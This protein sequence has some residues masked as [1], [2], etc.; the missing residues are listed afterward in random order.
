MV[1]L[2]LPGERLAGLISKGRVICL[3]T[4]SRAQL[5]G[6]L[7]NLLSQVASMLECPF[8]LPRTTQ[9]K[10]KGG[11]KMNDLKK[12]KKK[13]DVITG[14]RNRKQTWRTPQRPGAEFGSPPPLLSCA[15][16]RVAAGSRGLFIA[17]LLYQT[18]GSSLFSCC[19]CLVGCRYKLD[20]RRCGE[21]PGQIP[22]RRLLT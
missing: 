14:N 3:Q 16:R 5:P 15:G 20:C 6:A 9:P 11:G 17:R 4:C 19:C 10:K 2:C 13:K 18:H 21:L 1:I 12:K 22:A 8:Y 7:L